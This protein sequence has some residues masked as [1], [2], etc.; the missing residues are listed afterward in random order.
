MSVPLAL[1]ATKPNGSN[2]KANLRVGLFLSCASMATEESTAEHG[3]IA[4]LSPG[5]L[6]LVVFV[7]GFSSLGAEV[8]ALRRL[9]PHLGSTITVT[10]PTIGLFLLAL[11][12]G[13]QAGGKLASG[14]LE[15]IQRNFLLAAVLILVGLS[16]VGVAGIFEHV[17]PDWL[18]YLVF[19][20]LVLCPIAYLLGQ[21]V[22]ILTNLLRHERVGAR[23]GMALYWS[24]LGSFVG[25]IGLSLIVMQ[26]LGVPSAVLICGCLLL[27]VVPF[28]PTSGPSWQRYGSVAACAA[29]GAFLNLA[30]PATTET[31]YA[32]YRIDPVTVT[33]MIEP[34]VLRSNNSAASLIDQSN[35]P[36]YARYVDRL[37][38]LFI[39]ELGYRDKHFLV[40]G[41]GG[42]TLSHL[43]PLNRYTYI[44]IDAAIKP[45]AEEEFL[46]QAIRGEFIDADARG[47]LVESIRRRDAYDV[48]VVDVFTALNNVPSHLATREFWQDTRQVL[49]A[50]GLMAANL[51][52]DSRLATEY[53][54]N[55]LAT[56]QAAY[57]RCAVEVLFRDRPLSN[58]LVQCYKH[59]ENS[60]VMIYTDERNRADVDAARS[61]QTVR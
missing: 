47:Y 6:M 55:M 36:H 1:P 52:L 27:L 18:A 51:I 45:L 4:S 48:V 25:S 43:E 58:V 61:Q 14:Y 22:P 21:T 34:Q 40:L 28:L 11:A 41:A 8:L 9:V 23:S 59:G 53:A 39:D 60:G 19:V 44:D 38:Q 7:E 33:G 54:Q 13:Y 46:K 10:A 56:I 12:L 2:E 32:S 50:D 37:R 30:V 20:G 17:R 3:V 5:L 57:G 15:K 29:V 42:F 26:W 24:T 16:R 35:P 49:A 31:A